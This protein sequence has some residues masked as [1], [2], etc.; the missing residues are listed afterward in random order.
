MKPKLSKAAIQ[1][2]EQIDDSF[3]ERDRA[4]DGWIADQRHMRAGKSDHIPDGAGW[5]RAL[6]VD[7]DLSGRSKPE[8]MP[9]L[10]NEIRLYAKSDSKKRIAYI[11][12]S[13][14][15]ASPILGWKWRKYTGANQHKSHCH[16]S[17]TKK[18]DEDGAFFQI[19]MLGVNNERTKEDVRVVGKSISCSCTHSC[20]LG[21]N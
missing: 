13:G 17:F 8:I 18:A 19:P 16:V 14:R 12:F 5:V 3:P 4:S 6:D 7:A 10:A 1:L 15:I 20:S 21:S 9:D 2:R 11:I